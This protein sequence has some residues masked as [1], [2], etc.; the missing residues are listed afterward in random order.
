M[1]GAV[2][3]ALVIAGGTTARAEGGSTPS[4]SP[5]Q[6]SPSPAATPTPSPSFNSSHQS[7]TGDGPTP[8]ATPKPKPSAIP[9]PTAAPIVDP[10]NTPEPT[11]T[12]GDGGTVT[13]P[14]ATAAPA[15]S[16][17]GSST[18]QP[19]PATHDPGDP[20]PFVPAPAASGSTI[21]SLN[22]DSAHIP[23]IE[24]LSPV[25]GLTFGKSLQLGPILLLIDLLGMAALYYF[26]RY[27]WR[28]P[29]A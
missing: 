19:P 21:Q 27:R 14:E 22:L 1:L 9:T 18:P 7:G 24:A 28:T 13:T 29:V 25:S 12:A 16:T 23:P 26:V 8:S 10:T 5:G 3:F 4:S 17:S 2:A 15:L 20:A 6:A 11:P